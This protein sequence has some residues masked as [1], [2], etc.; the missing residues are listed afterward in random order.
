VKEVS[1]KASLFFNT[2]IEQIYSH[3]EINTKQDLLDLICSPKNISG[4]YTKESTWKTLFPDFYNELM[5]W[6]FPDVFIFKQKVYHYLNNDPDL[7]LGLCNVCGKRCKLVGIDR[8]YTKYCS[9]RCV[10]DSEER[11]SLFKETCLKIYGH[12][13]PSQSRDIQEKKKQTCLE[14]Y[15]VEHSSQSEEIRERTKQTCLEK[16]GCECYF[17]TETYRNKYND[18]EWVK[19]KKEKETQTCIDKYG[20]ENYTQTE[21]FKRKFENHEWL[22][23]LNKKRDKT[24]KKNNTFNTSKIEDQL[25]EYF[26]LNNIKYIP[27]YKSDLYPFNCDFYFPEKDLYVEIQGSWTHGPHPFTGSEED[28]DTLKLWESKGSKYYENAI[29]VWTIRDVKKRETAKKNKLNWVEIFSYDLD[30][31][32]S[33]ISQSLG[34]HQS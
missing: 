8:G 15:G 29:E 26:T 21:E 9:S 1:F 7:Q 6:V 32:V 4:Y 3:T 14:R 20:V 11:R 27:Q 19:K 12:E 33:M 28:L 25:K 17:Q 22:Q 2:Y 30:E 5:A 31:C 24:K 23:K 10:Y 18:N 13:N 34:D 16:Y